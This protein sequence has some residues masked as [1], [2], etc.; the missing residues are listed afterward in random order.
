MRELYR[1]TVYFHGPQTNWGRK[2]AEAEIVAKDHAP[3]LWLA[4][5]RARS[6]LSDLNRGRCGYAISQGE[7]LIEHREADNPELVQ[8]AI[9]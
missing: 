5:L 9:G 6:L 1:V 4:R 3:F 7:R 8:V 2:I